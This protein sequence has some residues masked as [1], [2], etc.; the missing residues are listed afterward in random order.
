MGKTK[1]FI[2]KTA[3]KLAVR[4]VKK[5]A[6]KLAADA[7]KETVKTYTEDAKSR[8]IGNLT[9]RTMRE[10]D[11][12]E[13]LE[14][15]REFYTS[16]ATLTNGSDQIFNKDISECV[17]D[18]PFLEG[19]VFAF[20]DSDSSLWGYAMLAHSFSTE[21][22]KPCIWIEDLYLRE[23]VRS[24]GLASGFLSYVEEMYPESLFRLEAEYENE[25]AMEIYKR[26]GFQEFPYVEM[27]RETP[28]EQ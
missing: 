21:F 15:M 13:V 24:Q 10:K 26:K 7:A 11:R 18:S 4:A 23:E 2:I 9:L 27:I 8:T 1:K 6:K 3:G 17:S 28:A 5:G 12:A 20:K 14:M 25:H 16:E 22:G 19:Y